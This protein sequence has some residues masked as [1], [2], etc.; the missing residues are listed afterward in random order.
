MMAIKT[1]ISSPKMKA[2]CAIAN[3]FEV[4]IDQSKTRFIIPHATFLQAMKGASGT[5]FSDF[6]SNK[7]R[8]VNF[9]SIAVSVEGVTKCL[10]SRLI[11]H[12]SNCLPCVRF[13]MSSTLSLDQCF[14]S[15]LTG[16]Q[17]VIKFG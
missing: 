11:V 13:N 5:C 10:E 16:L 14:D 12:L 4:M 9:G 1:I 2:Y 3:V 17:V 7:K 8:G 6:R 15:Q